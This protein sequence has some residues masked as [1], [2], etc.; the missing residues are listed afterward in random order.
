M[1]GFGVT[2]TITAGRGDFGVGDQHVDALDRGEADEV[3]TAHLRRVGHHHDIVG[4]VHHRALD[5]GLFAV[6]CRQAVSDADRVGA[7][8][9]DV[10]AQR[11]EK[12][13]RGLTDR[14]LGQATDAPAQQLKRYRR[15]GRQPR[16]DGHRVGDDDQIPVRGKQRRDTAGGGAGVEQHAAAGYR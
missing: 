1:L 6:G 15:H 8:E 3:L 7:N 5:R 16:G 11:V 12:S 2:V 13:Q 10:H 14:G 9:R 4:G